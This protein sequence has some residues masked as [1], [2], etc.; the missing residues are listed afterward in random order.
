M[1]VGNDRSHHG[2]GVTGRTLSS[3]ASPSPTFRTPRRNLIRYGGKELESSRALRDYNVQKDATINLSLRLLGGDEVRAGVTGPH[4]TGSRKLGSRGTNP[5][6]SHHHHLARWTTSRTDCPHHLL[7]VRSWS[8]N[9]DSASMSP[10]LT[11][12]LAPPGGAVNGLRAAV[13]SCHRRVL[14]P[15]CTLLLPHLRD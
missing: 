12:T 7:S 2:A 1:M 15:D 5:S 8:L 4:T 11:L 3:P 9:L 13:V 10:P 6:A 14:R